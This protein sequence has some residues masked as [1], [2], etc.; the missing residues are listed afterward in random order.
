VI[1][2]GLALTHSLR[3]GALANP[4]ATFQIPSDTT[5]GHN[6][7][8]LVSQLCGNLYASGYPAANLP[9]GYSYW[10]SDGAFAGD[11][12][13]HLF[14]YSHYYKIMTDADRGAVVTGISGASYNRVCGILLNF[15]RK[16]RSVSIGP[17]GSYGSG[18]S[19][20][21]MTLNDDS[22]VAPGH[23]YVGFGHGEFT[24]NDGD[25]ALNGDGTPEGSF[26]NTPGSYD[27]VAGGGSASVTRTLYN[28]YPRHQSS[29][30]P[31]TGTGGVGS[32]MVVSK[33]GDSGA[34]NVLSGALIHLF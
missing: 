27:P 20:F 26:Y 18:A 6:S 28:F 14:R 8:I 32:N 30:P 34:F 2:D 10:L 16:I 31:G 13:T 33:S 12:S 29:D 21:S 25:V 19:N 23:L 24:V 4:G 11:G 5:F 7:L 1:Y 22:I 17:G 3:F 9:A 15:N